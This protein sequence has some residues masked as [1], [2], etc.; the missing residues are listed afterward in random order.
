MKAVLILLLTL[1]G[2]VSPGTSID[3]ERDPETGAIHAN[4]ERGWLAGPVDITGEY[5]A[6]DGTHVEFRWK[7]EIDLEAAQSVAALQQAN[8]AKAL[9]LAAAAAKSAGG[10]P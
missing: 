10:A 2:C 1:S 7:A 4:L 8:M 3:I 5:T 9:E 6:P